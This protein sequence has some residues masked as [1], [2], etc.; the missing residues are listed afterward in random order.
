MSNETLTT[1]DGDALELGD[2]F[3]DNAGPSKMR[4]RPKLDAPKEAVNIRLD[5]D[6]IKE[7]RRSGKGWQSRVN[8]ALRK[9][10][11]HEA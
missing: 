6:L 1:A 8:S 2:A 10:F 4:G 3:F 5:C 9:E 7:L 11:L